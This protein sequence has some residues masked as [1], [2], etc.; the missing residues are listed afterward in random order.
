MRFEARTDDYKHY[1][2]WDIT[3]EKWHGARDL[4]ATWCPNGSPRTQ[5]ALWPRRPRGQTRRFGTSAHHTPAEA[6]V[7]AQR[8]A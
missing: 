5:R 2:V 7:I 1:G 4:E 8:L 3:A 6:R